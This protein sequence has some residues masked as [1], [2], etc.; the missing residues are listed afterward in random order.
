MD[1]K[2]NTFIDSSRVFSEEEI[3][4]ALLQWQLLKQK[5]SP[6]ELAKNSQFQFF[7]NFL[8]QAAAQKKKLLEQKQQQQQQQQQQQ[9][10]PSV[11]FAVSPR[12]NPNSEQPPAVNGPIKTYNTRTGLAPNFDEMLL[13]QTKYFQFLMQKKEIPADLKQLIESDANKCTIENY[14][15]L[16]QHIGM[17]MFQLKQNQV[18]QPIEKD[19][20]GTIDNPPPQPQPSINNSSAQMFASNPPSNIKQQQSSAIPPNMNSPQMTNKE[21]K[22]T[23]PVV[24]PEPKKENKPMDMKIP[25][26]KPIFDSK[27]SNLQVED[28]TDPHL[29]VDTFNLPEQQER[30]LASLK[31]A[32]AANADDRQ[33]NVNI[34]DINEYEKYLIEKYRP[35]VNNLKSNKKNDI[36]YEDL[37]NLKIYPSELPEGI[38]LYKILELYQFSINLFKEYDLENCFT[39]LMILDHYKQNFPENEVNDVIAEVELRI[40]ELQL[41]QVQKNLRGE[42]IQYNSFN[43]QLL[44]SK[45]NLLNSPLKNNMYGQYKTL[46]YSDIKFVENSVAKIELE[47]KERLQLSHKNEINDMLSVFQTIQVPSSVESLVI[48][49]SNL[50]AQLKN[51]QQ[52]NTFLLK[53]DTKRIER[54]AKKRLQALKENDEEAYVKLLDQTKDTRITRLLKQTNSFLKSL[55]SA[56]KDQQDYTKDKIKQNTDVKVDYSNVVQDE[57][58]QEDEDDDNTDYYS[59]AHRIKEPILTQPTILVGGQL[60]DYQLKGLEWMISLYNN[61]LNGILADEMGL[62]KTVQT[63]S[64]LTY[65]YEH[66]GIKGPFL[67]LVP[68]STMTN[69]V[70]EFKRW[71]PAL[72]VIAY[73]GTPYE[74][75]NMQKRI[76]SLEF[77]VCLT[78]FE[79]I[80]REKAV[81][82]KVKWVHMIIDEGHRMKNAESKLSLTI[83][84]FYHTDYR[85]IL[86]GTP[87]QNNLP[88]LWALMNFVLPKIFNSGKSFDDWFNT[89]FANTG[90]QDKLE[91]TE[92]ETLLIIRR[93]HKV[94]RPFLLRRLKKDVEK[95]LPTKIERVIK[96]KKTSLQQILYEQM[97]KYKKIY[98]SADSTSKSLQA[99]GFNNQIMQL[100]KICNHPFVFPQVEDSLMIEKG[101]V[102]NLIYRTSGKFAL[103]KSILPKLQATNHRVL[104]FFQMTTVMDI[105]QDFLNLLGIKHFRLD[106]GTKTDERTVMLNEFNAPDSEYFCFLL[107]T[108]A[109]GLG[110]NLQTADTVIIFDSDWNPHQDLQ[111]QDRAHRI[112]QKNEVRILRLITEDSVEEVIL[113]KARSKLDLDGKV[114]QAGK[115][116]NKSTAEEQEFLLRDL[117]R[118]EEERQL[119]LQEKEKL[120]MQMKAGEAEENYDDDDFD[121]DE[122]N[123]LLA[124]GKDDLEIFKRMDIEAR[125]EDLDQGIVARM[126]QRRE[127]PDIYNLDI[128]LEIEKEK[129]AE[130]AKALDSIAGGRLAKRKTVSYLDDDSKWLKQLE[131]S[132]EDDVADYDE[133]IEDELEGLELDEDGELVEPQED[134]KRKQSI[135]FDDG[136]EGEPLKKKRKRGRPKKA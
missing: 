60:K 103:L 131:V 66:K 19:I 40:K 61:K 58:V 70:N 113:E 21:Q 104:I 34:D 17:R 42:I 78:T 121:N 30:G 33:E 13:A 119:K 97:L 89:P 133:K 83:N 84:K 71:A 129:K 2:G 118:K 77:D 69:W 1:N 9:H 108:R 14:K 99:K 126:I 80:I 125:K 101:T 51:H 64:L 67:V 105:M 63:L 39:I 134:G 93:L 117:M 128:A 47:N 48:K 56:V 107:S 72:N 130:E 12:S 10:R 18:S 35:S 45:Y 115:F 87:L 127:L 54:N 52:N 15:P 73:K 16:V 31:A 41:S 11:D 38:K 62:G 26:W 91:L 37:D 120:K 27:I 86:T 32:N 102:N 22:S 74:R 7:T 49:E 68:L 110:L 36:G 23:T 76:K 57:N 28:V 5:L 109:G 88:E 92:E 46:D 50:K 95:E 44:L 6:E 24:K 111:A 43:K 132:D 59:V 29:R 112:G 8:R 65:L 116:D 135:V 136:E 96:C 25:I 100:K 82:S 98:T 55:T 20:N 4:R 114:I 75:K 79:Y 3:N 122:V 94:L 123:E 81:L 106:G 85:L 124:R 53:E 90:S